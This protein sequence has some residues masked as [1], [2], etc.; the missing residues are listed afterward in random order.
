MRKLLFI[1]ALLAFT[2]IARAQTPLIFDDDC[3][4]DVDCAAT[5]PILFTLEDR[6]DIKILAALADSANP[7]SAPVMKLFANY[8]HHPATSVGAN[9][10]NLPDTAQSVTNKS[11]VSDWTV[12]LVARFDPNDARA[13]YPP[14]ANVYR[15]VLS[16]AA[17]HT[18][19]IAATGFSLC[20]NQLLASKGDA[21]SGL[22]GIKLVK[23][24]VKLLSVM[25]GQYPTGKEWNFTSDS[26]GWH[27]LITLWTRQH[28]F[29]PIYFNGF[30][31]GLHILAGPPAGTDPK[32][33]PTR[34]AF[35]IAHIH[36]RPMW[37]VLSILFA[38]WGPTH[39]GTTYFTVSAPGTIHLNPATGLTQWD[40]TKNSG[41]FY[42]TTAAP[43]Q[44]FE[45]LLDGYTHHGILATEPA[46]SGAKP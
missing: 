28:G 23:R 31:N 34:Y 7:L 21:I 19:V 5:M 32:I 9:L 2:T 24:K 37:D 43:N 15:Q 30:R 38:A 14:C 11:N 44:A 16:Q 12:P 40:T 36:Q 41:D 13:N 46:A 35:D 6:G 8:M 33:N 17:D 29:P 10:T 3:S 22:S 39:N 25:G 42:I 20:L 18:V 4:Q 27:A 45:S 1:A 26:P